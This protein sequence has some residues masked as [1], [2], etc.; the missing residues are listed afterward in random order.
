MSDT[1]NSG[2][3]ASNNPV[4]GRRSWLSRHRWIPTVI[5]T[6]I[7]GAVGSGVWD[8]L[9]KPSVPKIGEYAL[10][11]LTFGIDSLRD[12]IYQQIAKGGTEHAGLYLLSSFS[13]ILFG[14][15]ASIL[16][17]F[18]V[19][20]NSKKESLRQSMDKAT[21]RKGYP[22]VIFMGAMLIIFAINST[23]TIYIVTAGN[24]ITQMQHIA[25]PYI[26]K[27]QR[28]Y[29]RS[30]VA[31]MASK[32]DYDSINDYLGGVL[33]QQKIDAPPFTIF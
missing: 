19:V 6:I 15:T 24:H 12:G 28:V 29:V 7:L 16:F 26:S 30:Q 9:V 27:E 18:V 5:G 20:K 25:G 31:R 11:I 17:M 22:L 23:K 8:T 32:K 33:K 14:G 10:Y 4:A 1:D 13:G 21:G 2:S 3:T